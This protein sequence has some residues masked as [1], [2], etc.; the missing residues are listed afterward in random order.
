MSEVEEQIEIE[1]ENVEDSTAIEEQ[2]DIEEEQNNNSQPTV[3]GDHKPKKQPRTPKQIAA[4]E[5]ARQKLTGKRQAQ[6]KVEME[7]ELTVQQEI[8][9]LLGE[10]AKLR[11]QSVVLQQQVEAPVKVAKPKKK[12]QRVI[13]SESDSDSDSD[14][15]YVIE[16]KKKHKTP[17]KKPILTNNPLE[18]TGLLRSFG[19]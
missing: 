5:N 11:E 18:T 6:R 15:G 2:Q 1:P 17:P 7:K 14:D 10:N 12:K 4:L 3:D 13:V 9:R 19:F 16:K 8:N